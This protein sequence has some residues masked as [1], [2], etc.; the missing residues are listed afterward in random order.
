MDGSLGPLVFGMLSLPDNALPR[1]A[2]RSGAVR[3]S[4]DLQYGIPEQ[5]LPI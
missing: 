1:L 5:E 2:P 4:E 3:V